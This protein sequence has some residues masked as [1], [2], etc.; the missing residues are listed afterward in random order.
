MSPFV[1]FLLVVGASFVSSWLF[2]TLVS[3]SLGQRLVA[4]VGLY[5]LTT[6]AGLKSARTYLTASAGLAVNALVPGDYQDD[7]DGAPCTPKGSL[8][9]LAEMMLA[10]GAF[11]KLVTDFLS[12]RRET[13]AE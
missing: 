13:V 12:D 4:R 8:A 5:D 9:E 10:T 2:E 11:L 1:R 3:S 6:V 7:D